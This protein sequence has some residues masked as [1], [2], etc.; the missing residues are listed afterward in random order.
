MSPVLSF[1]NVG[2]RFGGTD[3]APAVDGVSLE[4]NQGEI[5]GLVGESGSGK[6]T[7]ANAF[8]GLLPENAWVT[9]SIRFDGREF[10]GL[11]DE[12]LRQIR[13]DQVAM[14][15]QDPSASLDPT[16]SVGD[17]I[18]E[19]IRAHRPVTSSGGLG[20]Q[21]LQVFQILPQEP[22]RPRIAKIPCI[23]PG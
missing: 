5:F 21:L 11:T 4:V 18:A 3:A 8:M 19:T 14:I 1:A 20:L 2:V 16:W 15:F 22:I 12:D 7:L 9:G 13:G 23:F 6:S 17:Q 10:V